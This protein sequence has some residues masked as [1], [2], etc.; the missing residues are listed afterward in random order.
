MMEQ[1]A[2]FK[3]DGGFKSLLINLLEIYS[4]KIIR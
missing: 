2:I 1:M 3:M 4:Y